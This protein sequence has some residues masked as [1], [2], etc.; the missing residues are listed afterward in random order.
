VLQERNAG[1]SSF[2]R[3]R[4]REAARLILALALGVVAIACIDPRGPKPGYRLGGDHVEA[5]VEDWRFT[6]AI[7]LVF[8]QTRPWYGIPHSATLWCVELDERLYIGSYGDSSAPSEFKRWERDIR[9][10]PH[11]RLRVD[12]KIYDVRVKPV[13]EPATANALNVAYAKKYDM[14][15]VFRGEVPE[16]WYYEVVQRDP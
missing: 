12:E 14:A 8:I 16:W 6:N 15:A 7:D 4:M 11:A 3:P 13:A 2:R 10:N 9:R 5:P 1:K